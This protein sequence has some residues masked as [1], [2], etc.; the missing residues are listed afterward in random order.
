MLVMAQL[1]PVHQLEQVE[2]GVRILVCACS[3]A[4]QTELDQWCGN[5][6][7]GE[8]RL[9]KCMADELA[10]EAKPGYKGTKASAACAVE[11]ERFRIARS[12]N[13]NADLPLAKACKADAD[14]LCA[15][16]YDVRAPAAAHAC[17]SPFSRAP[18]M[19]KIMLAQEAPFACRGCCMQQ[20][21]VFEAFTHAISRGLQFNPKH[22][23]SPCLQEV[24]A[25]ADACAAVGGCMRRLNRGLRGP[26][27][28]CMC[29]LSE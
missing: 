15:T 5:V 21:G 9:A 29:G 18:A 8:G 25:H 4:C 3:G 14:K 26:R 12:Q 13:I 22:T 11:L 1:A 16:K 19:C 23:L 6:K 7:P 20:A 2:N 24:C 10:D 28:G 17:G 27:E